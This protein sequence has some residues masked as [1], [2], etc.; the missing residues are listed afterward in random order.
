M[1]RGDRKKTEQWL[2]P[3]IAQ[4]PTEYKRH[5]HIAHQSANEGEQNVDKQKDM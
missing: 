3:S 4:S 5:I 1:E 2:L